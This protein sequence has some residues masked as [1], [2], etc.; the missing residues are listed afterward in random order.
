MIAMASLESNG[1]QVLR[2]YAIRIE[3]L[4]RPSPEYAGRV[5]I[6]ALGFPAT[7]HPERR[8]DEWKP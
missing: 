1:R 7:L 5:W 8:K 3:D 4:M 6:E 2:C